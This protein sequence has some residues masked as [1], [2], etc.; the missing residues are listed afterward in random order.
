M[1]STLSAAFISKFTVSDGTVSLQP[2]PLHPGA[3]VKAGM[4]DSSTGRDFDGDVFLACNQQMIPPD[5][6]TRPEQMLLQ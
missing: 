5:L 1:L 2:Q 6:L 3:Q 4:H